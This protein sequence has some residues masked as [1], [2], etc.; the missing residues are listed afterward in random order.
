[1]KEACILQTP[2]IPPNENI[3]NDDFF[4]FSRRRF[5]C[6]TTA[7][8]LNPDSRREKEKEKKKPFWFLKV[9]SVPLPLEK[10]SIKTK[11]CCGVTAAR[12]LDLYFYT[13]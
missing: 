7:C 9:L 11:S 3:E 8:Y 6:Q 12:A 13:E 4:L 1:M 5:L 10:R 2:V